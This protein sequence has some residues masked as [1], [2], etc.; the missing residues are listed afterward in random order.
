MK[1]KLVV[2]VCCAPD[3]AWVLE[4]LHKE[5]ELLCFFS[6]ANIEPQ[7]EYDKRLEDFYRVASHYNCPTYE[8]A[9][10][11]KE[12]RDVIAEFANTPEGGTRCEHCFLY[13]LRRTAQFCKKQGFNQFTTTMSISPHKRIE[14]L[15]R[16]G[17][18]AA[19][20]HGITYKGYNFKKKGGFQN[21]IVLS[22]E[23]GL[24]RQDYCGCYLS[25][26]ERDER[27][28]KK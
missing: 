28:K 23:L 20:E 9:Y 12:W 13:R 3:Q 7:K 2:H 17:N 27:F 18:L 1:E 8:D 10:S 19:Q 11:P 21:S 24:Y 4:I 15:H 25:L 5:Y 16:A 22:K 26:A 14:L 6:N